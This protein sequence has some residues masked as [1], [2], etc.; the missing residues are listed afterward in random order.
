MQF[1]RFSSPATARLDR[2]EPM[3]AADRERRTIGWDPFDRSVLALWVPPMAEAYSAGP[4]ARRSAVLGSFA[5]TIVGLIS[6]VAVW[7]IAVR[8]TI[9]QR[10]D[11]AV[12]AGQQVQDLWFR[13]AVF[14]RAAYHSAIPLIAAVLLCG[15]MIMI[16]RRWRGGAAAITVLVGS[17]ATTEFAKHVVIHRPDLTGRFAGDGTNSFPSGHTTVAVAVAVVILMVLP[18]SW[19]AIGTLV[20]ACGATLVANGTMTVGWHR[21]SDAIGAVA[22][23]MLWTGLVLLIGLWRGTFDVVEGA[24]IGFWPL[25]TTATL[26]VGTIVWAVFRLRFDLR[27]VRQG[28]ELPVDQLTHL[29]STGD[30]LVMGSVLCGISACSMALRNVRFV[31]AGSTPRPA[32]ASS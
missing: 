10:F 20:T 1:R 18:R 4:R 8:T 25:V 23:V 6:A 15:A 31:P 12:L 26:G 3:K 17:L 11:D 28:G 5:L 16:R 13:W 22:I 2:G 24:P 27:W 14:G 30:L 7:A 29:F 9:G 21:A 32:V 19:R